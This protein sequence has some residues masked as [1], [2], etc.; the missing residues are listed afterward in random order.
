MRSN[1]TYSWE[2]SKNAE[3]IKSHHVPQEMALTVIFFGDCQNRSQETDVRD[4]FGFAGY[5]TFSS[6]L[7]KIVQKLSY[8]SQFVG[9]CTS[10][11]VVMELIDW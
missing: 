5:H 1:L 7:C 2:R 3:K 11:M 10:D 6:I 9:F 8:Q 4:M